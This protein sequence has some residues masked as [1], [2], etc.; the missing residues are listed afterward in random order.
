MEEVLKSISEFVEGCLAFLGGNGN[1]WDAWIRDF[2]IQACATLL[3]F[4]CV[5][6]FLW[7]PITNFLE[8]RKNAID[9]ELDEAKEN[10]QKALELQQELQNKYDNAKEEIKELIKEATLEGNKRKEEIISEA[11]EEASKRIALANEEIELEIKK[12][13]DSIK[14][15]IVDIAFLAAEKIIGRE[16]NRKEYLALVEEIIESGNN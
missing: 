16:V 1:A 4:L 5:R 12:Q 15:E 7:K 10:N 9:K 8:A 2:C 13:K 14:E 11:K 3:L 6:F